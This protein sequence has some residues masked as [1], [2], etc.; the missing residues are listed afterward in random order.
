MFYY[1]YP[2]TSDLI[3]FFCIS[4]L[5]RI[6]LALSGTDNNVYLL[7][8]ELNIADRN[9]IELVNQDFY[10]QEVMFFSCRL[11]EI[12]VKTLE[13]QA[14]SFINGVACSNLDTIASVSNDMT[15]SNWYHLN[16]RFTCENSYVYGRMQRLVHESN[17]RHRHVGWPFIL[18][19]KLM[20]Y[21]VFAYIFVL[22][23]SILLEMIR[24]PTYQEERL[25]VA[26]RRGV[27]HA[28]ALAGSELWWFLFSRRLVN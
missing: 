20:G 27:V 8:N 18:S 3:C 15:V 25:L 11:G 26:E 10:F 16:T 12:K 13:G 14:Q 4:S 24:K 17:S 5:H 1:I 7:E 2:I 23:I 9:N 22:L 28:L 21:P 6:K 19:S